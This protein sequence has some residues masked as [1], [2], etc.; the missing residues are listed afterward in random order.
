MGYS[1]RDQLMT[2]ESI[3]ENHLNLTPAALVEA[4]IARNEGVLANT[5]AL[6][7]TTGKRTGIG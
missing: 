3:A 6:V 4:A 2:K 1:P 7:V 5:G